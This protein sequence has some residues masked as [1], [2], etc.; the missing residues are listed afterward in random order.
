MCGDRGRG[1]REGGEGVLVCMY[2]HIV[3]HT[4]DGIHA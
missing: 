4:F 3:Y 1:E 2:V